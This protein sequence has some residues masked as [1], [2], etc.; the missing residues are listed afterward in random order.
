DSDACWML[1]LFA[2]RL[3]GEAQAFEDLGI[4]YC[5]TFEVS[6]PQWEPL[7][8]SIRPVPAAGETASIGNAS[9]VSGSPPAE[10]NAFILTGEIS[11]RMQQ[12]M[13]ALRSFAAGRSDIVVDCRPLRRIEFVAAGELLNEVVN[14]RSAGKQV[15]FAEP[16]R[17]VYALMLVMGIQELAEVRRRKI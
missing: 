5:V 4:E 1:A 17:L 16:N 9:E 12:E 2:L 7:P 8:A 10:P 15:L 14:L 11:G 6:P 13:Q 3:L